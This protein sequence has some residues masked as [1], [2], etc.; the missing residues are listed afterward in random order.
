MGENVEYQN[1]VIPAVNDTV[2]VF[3]DQS[4][5]DT[6]SNPFKWY[7]DLSKPA[8]MVWVQTDQ[9]AQITQINGKTLKS[10]KPIAANVPFQLSQ[11][12]GRYLKITQMKI[13]IST[14]ANTLVEVLGI[15]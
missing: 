10:P 13:K 11:V 15:C 9:I 7:F 2:E 1:D 14:T 6:T 12:Y 4:G 5:T 8:V 3:F